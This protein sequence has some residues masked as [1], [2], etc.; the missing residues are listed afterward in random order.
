LCIISTDRFKRDYCKSS[1][2]SLSSISFILQ[3]QM[4]LL[5]LW[6]QKNPKSH[7]PQLRCSCHPNEILKIKS[8]ELNA[9]PILNTFYRQNVWENKVTIPAHKQN[10]FNAFVRFSLC[11]EGRSCRLNEILSFTLHYS[12]NWIYRETDRG[13]VYLMHKRVD[14]KIHRNSHTNHSKWSKQ[15]KFW[16]YTTYI[17]LPGYF[18]I[19]GM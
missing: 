1:I 8:L 5:W 15:T 6:R 12:I 2:S 7:R 13:I 19:T 4:L 3:A 9:T 16:S 14:P 18:F 17:W 10:L 11:F